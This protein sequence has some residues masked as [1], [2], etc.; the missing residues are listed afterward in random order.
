MLYVIS[1]SFGVK[2]SAFI[3]QVLTQR[4][5]V[6]IIFNRLQNRYRHPNTFVNKVAPSLYVKDNVNLFCRKPCLLYIIFVSTL[7]IR[8]ILWFSVCY[9]AT[10]ARREI[11][12]INAFRGKRHQ[13]GSPILQD[14]FIGGKLLWD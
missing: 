7:D 13:L 5:S 12:A 1:R 14:I 9:T 8:W 2:I 3:F 10:T 4:K 6:Q 11:F